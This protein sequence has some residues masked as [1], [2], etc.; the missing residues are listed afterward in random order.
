MIP[1]LSLSIP[2]HAA[3]VESL[4]SNLR[5]D[6]AQL[7][8]GGKY[9]SQTAAVRDIIADVATRGDAALTDNARKFDFAEFTPEMIRVTSAEMREASARARRSVERYSPLHRAGAR[10]SNAYSSGRSRAT[11]A[12]GG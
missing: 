11:D 10:I 6:A 2:E 4:L 12:Q 9:A 5:L 1:I 7:A 3:R 8:A